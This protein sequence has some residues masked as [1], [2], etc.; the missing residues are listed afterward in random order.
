MST[1]AFLPTGNTRRLDVTNTSASVQVSTAATGGASGSLQ[2]LVTNGG[3]K[4]GFVTMGVGSATAVEPV[5]GTPA[6][7]MPLAAGGAQVWS[8][9]PNAFFAAV[10]NGADT[11]TIYITPGDGQ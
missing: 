8:G 4:M 11:T 5:V 6:N 1:N 3:T 2:Y 10:T 7:G 9:P